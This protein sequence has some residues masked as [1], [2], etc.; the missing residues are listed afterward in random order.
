MLAPP[1]LLALAAAVL[2]QQ[3]MPKEAVEREKEV[4]KWVEANPF[5][6]GGA[7]PPDSGR[8]ERWLAVSM[9]QQDSCAD[10]ADDERGKVEICRQCTGKPLP[11][12]ACPPN[13]SCAPQQVCQSAGEPL[14]LS[15]PMNAPGPT[16]LAPPP[17]QAKPPPE[18]P[19]RTTGGCIARYLAQAQSGPDQKWA[20]QLSMAFAS[21]HMDREHASYVNCEDLPLRNTEHYLFHYHARVTS[22]VYNQFPLTFCAFSYGYTGIKALGVNTALGAQKASPPS[23]D[24]AYWGCR[25]LWDAYDKKVATGRD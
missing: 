11:K 18:P 24:E 6:K 14:H 20:D 2:A 17:R 4:R 19:K 5:L 23:L 12:P 1:L 25:G 7:L 16:V 10:L 15:A 13:T 22:Q 9:A 21:S 3:P 8:A